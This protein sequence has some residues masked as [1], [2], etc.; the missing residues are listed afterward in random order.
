MMT[1]NSIAEK[2]VLI[3][4]DEHD[5]A[6]LLCSILANAG[7]NVTTTYNCEDALSQV[8]KTRPDAITLDMQMPRESG[9]MFYRKL[10]ADEKLRDIPVVVVTGVTRDD[11][12]METLVRSLLE[13]DNVPHPEAYVEKPVDAPHFLKT[14]RDVLSSS[15]CGSC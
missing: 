2:R 4:E 6:A 8:R 15:T 10:K 14:I 12:E 11:K 9:A 7:Y 5:F 3:V 1:D 13:P